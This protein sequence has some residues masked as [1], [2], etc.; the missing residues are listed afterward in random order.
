MDEKKPRCPAMDWFHLE[1]EL[2][3]ERK[4][5]EEAEKS[6]GICFV[7][8]LIVQQLLV[9]SIVSA[10]GFDTM[11]VGVASYSAFGYGFLVGVCVS[12]IIKLIWCWVKRY[13]ERRK[14]KHD[15]GSLPKSPRGGL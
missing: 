3:Q 7:V 15:D 8:G 6:N 11:K 12:A 14:K 5:R 10:I 1:R 2:R 13:R 4:R 9:V